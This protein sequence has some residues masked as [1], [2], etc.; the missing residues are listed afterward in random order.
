E[1][2]A[3][4]GVVPGLGGPPGGVAAGIQVIPPFL[5]G[6]RGDVRPGLELPGVPELAGVAGPAVRARNENHQWPTDAAPFSP[7][8]APAAK[9]LN[10][11][12]AISSGVLPLATSSAIASPETGPALKP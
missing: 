1:P 7:I 4:G 6:D 3:A 2:P 9:R 5:G 8:R 12:G 11:N 10:P